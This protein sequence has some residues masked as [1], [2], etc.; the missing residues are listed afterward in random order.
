MESQKIKENRR[1][2]FLAKMEKNKA[3][4]KKETSKNKKSKEDLK[5]IP[6]ND[7]S[8]INP[9]KDIQTSKTE[10]S[11]AN[12]DKNKDNNMTTNINNNIDLNAIMNNINSIKYL[13]FI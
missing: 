11:S 4:S 6:T 5:Q 13:S 9:P 2:K 10:I 7:N 3:S 12:K 1:A 8:S